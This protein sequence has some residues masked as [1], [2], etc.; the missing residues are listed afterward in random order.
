MGGGGLEEAVK[1][2]EAE[3]GAF[4]QT[5]EQNVNQIVPSAQETASERFEAKDSSNGRSDVNMQEPKE[6]EQ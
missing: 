6:S 1:L 3:K 4:S 5:E 2:L